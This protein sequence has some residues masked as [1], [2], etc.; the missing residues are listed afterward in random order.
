[1]WDDSKSNST[2]NSGAGI[3]HDRDEVI[4]QQ[5]PE[6]LHSGEGQVF[7]GQ[8]QKLLTLTQPRFVLDFT[9]VAEL[10]A[11]GIY[12]L[13]QFLEEVMKLNG[14]VKLAAVPPGPAKI[15]EATGVDHLF[16]IFDCSADAVH[17]FHY[18]PLPE[19]A[20]DATLDKREAPAGAATPVY[21][22]D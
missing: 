19:C 1:M 3:W 8:M 22:A 14:D 12:L 4:V 6:K 10:D 5:L 7:F 11:A 20:M 18:L 16:E 2:E 15:L 17:S 21:G 13:L 9:Q